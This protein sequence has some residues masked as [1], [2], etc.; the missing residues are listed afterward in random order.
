MT[1]RKC[2]II[3]DFVMFNICKSGKVFFGYNTK[4]EFYSVIGIFTVINLRA[5]YKTRIN[6]KSAK[7]SEENYRK[8]NLMS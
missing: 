6:P 3:V 4:Y 7:N 1:R 2:L 8:L 5:Y